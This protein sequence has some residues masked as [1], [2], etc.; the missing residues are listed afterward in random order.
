MI[1]K[2]IYPTIFVLD[3]T[4]IFG[5]EILNSVYLMWVGFYSSINP[6]N[7]NDFTFYTTFLDLQI[8]IFFIFIIKSFLFLL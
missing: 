4:D 3:I 8:N 7:Q 5:I 2:L 6:S 1:S